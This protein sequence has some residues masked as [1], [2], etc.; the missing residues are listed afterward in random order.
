MF[1][2]MCLAVLDQKMIDLIIDIIPYMMSVFLNNIRIQIH[3]TQTIK[4]KS[5]QKISFFSKF[6]EIVPKTP[7]FGLKIR[8][9]NIE[10]IVCC[11][12]NS[13]LFSI[14]ISIRRLPWNC[15][16]KRTF[17]KNKPYE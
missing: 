6:T 4:I 15:L 14:F 13:N 2:I 17:T 1:H 5:W 10:C 16:L 11:T 3:S 7:N 12:N 9:A 8:C